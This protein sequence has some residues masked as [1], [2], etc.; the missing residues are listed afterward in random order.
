MLFISLLSCEQTPLPLL[1]PPS[2]T[3]H[4]PPIDSRCQTCCGMNGLLL[5]AG[6]RSRRCKQTHLIIGHQPGCSPLLPCYAHFPHRPLPSLSPPLPLALPPALPPLSPFKFC[7]PQTP[8][9][10]N[11]T[12]SKQ[13]R[14]CFFCEFCMCAFVCVCV[15]SVNLV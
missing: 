10:S 9:P 3:P 12:H 5:G 14:I 15:H 2:S 6:C 4:P 8:G 11:N 7:V 13:V 1:S